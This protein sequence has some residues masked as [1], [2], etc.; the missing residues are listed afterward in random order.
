VTRPEGDACEATWAAGVVKMVA[1]DDGWHVHEAIGDSIQIAGTS[2]DVGYV[3]GTLTLAQA[4]RVHLSVGGVAWDVR[5]DVDREGTTVR[6]EH[7][8]PTDEPVILRAVFTTD[9]GYVSLAEK[10]IG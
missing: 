7:E 2:L 5:N 4:G 1:L 8:V 10:V 6:F 3:G 9:T